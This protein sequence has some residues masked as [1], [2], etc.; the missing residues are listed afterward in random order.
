M[1][2]APLL[3][4]EEE[5]LLSDEEMMDIRK[6]AKNSKPVTKETKLFEKVYEL[7]TGKALAAALGLEDRI[8]PSKRLYHIRISKGV[9]GIQ[10]EV[11]EFVAGSA[12]S[13]VKEVAELLR[14]IRFEKTSEKE[15]SN[16]I[17]D[18]HRKGFT[19]ELFSKSQKSTAGTSL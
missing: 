16:G 12:D 2:Q 5:P 17:R 3:S 14:H 6:A 1:L 7:E 4:D 9:E 8:N 19:L 15:Y 11:D 13:E 10:E 18:K